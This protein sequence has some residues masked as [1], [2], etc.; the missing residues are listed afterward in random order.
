MSIN[1]L[2]LEIRHVN[3]ANGWDMVESES[4]NDKYFI[5]AKL[6]LV[7]SEVSEAFEEECQPVLTAYR[8][9]LADVV[10]RILDIVGGI[11]PNFAAMMNLV[12]A[13]QVRPDAFLMQLNLRIS[14]AL[15]AFRQDSKLDF[16]K[17]LAEA[18]SL[19]LA[20]EDL[21]DV[22]QSKIEKNRHRGHRHGGK[23]I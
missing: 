11:H 6:A 10:I 21:N 4:W 15:E 8:E 22:I 9:E 14:R 23:R 13:P 12:I 3:A 20:E 1:E 18:V 2:I 17:Q 5:P 19:I 7:H 16:L